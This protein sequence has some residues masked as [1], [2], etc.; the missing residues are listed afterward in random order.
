MD[1]TDAELAAAFGTQRASPS[2]SGPR[3]PRELISSAEA[4][5]ADLSPSARAYVEGIMDMTDA[6]LAAAFGTQRV[7]S[8]PRQ[9]RE[10]IRRPKR[11]WPI[12]AR[13]HAPT[14]RESWT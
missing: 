5:L 12:S 2:R 10:L 8:C 1:M 3:Q 6:E 11:C 7:P 13:A 14:S 4:V 9:P